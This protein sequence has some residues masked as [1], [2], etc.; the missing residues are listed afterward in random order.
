MRAGKSGRERERNGQPIRHSDHHVPDQIGRAEMLLVVGMRHETQDTVSTA[1]LKIRHSFAVFG[2][3]G[4]DPPG[5][6]DWVFPE[7]PL[8]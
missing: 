8:V 7:L 4:S 1:G 3:C 6:G 2:L 5:V